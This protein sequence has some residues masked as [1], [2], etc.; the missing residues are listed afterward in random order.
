MTMPAIAPPERLDDWAAGAGVVVADEGDE[1]VDED[2]VEDVV[3]DVDEVED[4]ELEED[5]DVED[6]A[7]LTRSECMIL[8]LTELVLT[9]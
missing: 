1:V 7:A 8:H 6:A 2:V 9:L 4:V 3:K 5:D